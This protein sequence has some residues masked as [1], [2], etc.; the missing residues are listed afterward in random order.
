MLE[1]RAVLTK[2][3]QYTRTAQYVDTVA[4]EDRSRGL[5]LELLNVGG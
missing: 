2:H 5:E 4:G 1:S 3:M